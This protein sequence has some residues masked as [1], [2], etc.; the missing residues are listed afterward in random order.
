[1][2]QPHLSDDQ[3]NSLAA[4]ENKAKE[5][6]MGVYRRMTPAQRVET[7]IRLSVTAREIKAAALR[8]LHPDRDE[9]RILGVVR[10][11]FLYARS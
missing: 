1:M 3:S 5:R 10:E 7:A 9:K 2:L 6:Q 11:T 4:E 8:S